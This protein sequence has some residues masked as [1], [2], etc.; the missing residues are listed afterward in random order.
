MVNEHDAGQQLHLP[1]TQEELHVGKRVVETGKGVRLRKTVSEEALTVDEDL[2]RQDLVVERVVIDRLLDSDIAP[3]QRYEGDTLVVPVLE[4]V[5]IVEKRL[6][7]K[8]EIRI[9]VKPDISRSSQRVVLRSEHLHVENIDE[10]DA[11]ARG[12]PGQ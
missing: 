6:R 1:I 8:E 5:L 10:Q 11:A 2:I 3:Q 9:T 7:L 4:E 12:P